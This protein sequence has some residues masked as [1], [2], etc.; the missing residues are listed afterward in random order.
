[1]LTP[2]GQ[3]CRVE[4]IDRLGAESP[5]TSLTADQQE[6]LRELLRALVAES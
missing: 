5:L 6:A 1:V 4:V 3:R 2:A